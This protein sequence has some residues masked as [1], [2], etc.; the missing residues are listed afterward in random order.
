[1]KKKKSIDFFSIAIVTTILLLASLIIYILSPKNEVEITTTQVRALIN[2]IR[3][4]YFSQYPDFNELYFSS[5]KGYE[6][7]N[8]TTD[9]LIIYLGSFSWGSAVEPKWSGK[10]IDVLVEIPE[11]KEKYT[12]FVPEKFNREI[13]KL[14]GLDTEERQRYTIENLTN[15]YY[16]II[17]EYLSHNSYKSVIIYGAAEGAYILPMLYSR[18][19]NNNI[20]ALISDSGGGG[21]TFAEQQQVLL[22]KLIKNERSFSALSSA[23]EDRA[24][25]QR[26]YETWLQA[27]Q[28]AASAARY[29]ASIDFFL[30]SPMTYKWFSGITQL[31]LTEYYEK[32]NIPV[33]FIHGNLDTTVPVETTQ[34]IENNF[35]NK[36][37]NFYYY[38]DMTHIQIKQQEY[39]PQNDLTAWIL[40]IDK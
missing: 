32:I 27:F 9:R 16:N 6:F 34:Y 26:Y 29:S 4:S 30:N 2:S 15:N 11:L 10:L 5:G 38:A 13:G 35:K 7:K 40:R 33:L 8:D 37:F 31:N 14:Y 20:T 1:M 19:D 17:T 28:T 3:E 21:L 39:P 25:M 23:K 18:L 22:N 12:F 24:N 36:S